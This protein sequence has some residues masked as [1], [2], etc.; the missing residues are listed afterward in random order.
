M[1][2]H[3]ELN[4]NGKAL[5]V[6]HVDDENV[7]LSTARE[8]ATQT[9]GGH[10]RASSDEVERAVGRLAELGL[11]DVEPGAEETLDVADGVSVVVAGL[12]D[13]DTDADCWRCRAAS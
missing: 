9:R 6:E 1:R 3:I 12:E 2:W 4:E 10:S 5:Q 13:A 11:D 7:A 8:L